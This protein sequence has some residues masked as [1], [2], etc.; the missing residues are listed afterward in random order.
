MH[1]EYVYTKKKRRDIT[2]H[3]IKAYREW[4]YRYTHY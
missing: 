4:K 3:R 2:V 1:A